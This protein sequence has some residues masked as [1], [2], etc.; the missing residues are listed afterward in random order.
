MPGRSY[1]RPGAGRRRSAAG[2][3]HRVGDLLLPA[4]EAAGSPHRGR[5]EGRQGETY[6]MGNVVPHL[7]EYRRNHVGDV[8]GVKIQ[9]QEMF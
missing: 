9:K 7:V 3:L 8:T 2:D 4:Q 6:I 1:G 5:Q